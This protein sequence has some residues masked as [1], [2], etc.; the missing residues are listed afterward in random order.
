MAHPLQD[1]NAAYCIA[2][3]ELMR[4][5]R[6]AQSAFR[7]AAVWAEASANEEVREFLAEARAADLLA[8]FDCTD[9]QGY[10]RWA[11]VL[12]F[13]CIPDEVVASE[14]MQSARCVE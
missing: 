11:F 3:A 13:R 2:L 14:Y 5:P 12:A 1:A 10:L 8:G 6:D 7:R 9:R 4:N